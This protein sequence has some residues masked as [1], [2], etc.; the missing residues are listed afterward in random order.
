MNKTH[1]TLILIAALL[2]LAICN[3]QAQGPEPDPEMKP[4]KLSP[5]DTFPTSLHAQG[6]SNGREN[7]YDSGPG[8]GAQ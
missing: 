3:T 8:L 1:V 4:G 5:E 7:I 6:P 2:V